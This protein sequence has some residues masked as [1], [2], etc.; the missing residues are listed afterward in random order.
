MG[1]L[2]FRPLVWADYRLAVLF[3]VIL[4]LVLLLWSLIRNAIA[5]QSLMLV[6]WRVASLLAI[7]VYLLIP[8]WRIGFL[9][10]LLARI[11]IPISLW[12]WVDLNEEIDDQPPRPLKLALTAW[13]WAVT[14]YCLL[15][16][17]ITL[18]FANC[19]FGS[20][21]ASP[22]CQVWREAPLL[23]KQ[24]LHPNQTPGF[25]GFIGGIGLFFY[26]LSLLYFLVFRLTKSGRTALEDR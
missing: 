16:A 5:M 15:G 17:A 9:T 6:Y 7:S 2:W 25:L 21:L 14:L 24:M 11:F 10:G 8:G 23:Y 18:P 12:F 26:G 3:T 19:I 22:Y 4:P 13:R 1:D 20:E